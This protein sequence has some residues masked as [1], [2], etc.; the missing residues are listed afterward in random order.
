MSDA[1]YSFV[2]F[3]VVATITPGGATTLA[4]ASGSQFGYVRSLPLMLGMAIGL[5]ALVGSTATG[6]AALI[7]TVPALSLGMRLVGTA[8]LL[9]LAL[10]IA[11]ARMPASVAAARA[12]PIGFAGGLM[13]L[14][15]NPK[16][17]TMAMG[18]AASFSELVA[19]PLHL[20]A[21]LGGTFGLAG[22]ISLSLWCLGGALLARSLR[23]ER[24]WM[25]LNVSLG[26]LLALSV[27][28]I[29]L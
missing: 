23:S 26:A 10:K 20:A 1:F 3:A 2:L 21:L 17:W 27:V 18:T 5:T 28:P 19:N 7:L 29:W 13:L 4:T 22:I 12:A 15:V 9:W 24:Q 11:G 8:Y 6:L 25:V 16:A 14:V